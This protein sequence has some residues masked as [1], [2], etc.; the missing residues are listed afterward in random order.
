[1]GRPSGRQ[2]C[3]EES[4]Q[5]Q[6][7]RHRSVPMRTGKADDCVGT[8]GV[9][10]R[11]RL[12]FDYGRGAFEHA[13]SQQQRPLL[14]GDRPSTPPRVGLMPR[15]D[16][17]ENAGGHHGRVAFPTYHAQPP[18]RLY[19]SESHVFSDGMQGA[20]PFI[21]QLQSSGPVLSV[22]IV[23]AAHNSNVL[24]GGRRTLRE[25]SPAQPQPAAGPE[26]LICAG[27]SRRPSQ[28][29]AH[30]VLVS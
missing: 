7:R 27:L 25:L 24:N 10:D 12:H 11:Q 23:H 13:S 4:T 22:P 26:R 21:H 28:Y 19:Q 17:F 20:F 6:T 29:C 14:H 18:P 5:Q 3:V 30:Q 8:P 1:M 2:P 15:Q 16:Q 9:A